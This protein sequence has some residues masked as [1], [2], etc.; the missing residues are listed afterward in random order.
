LRIND[1]RQRNRRRVEAEHHTAYR[2]SRT[3][4]QIHLSKARLL[5]HDDA[6]MNSLAKKIGVAIDWGNEGYGDGGVY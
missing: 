3:G 4:S 2:F 6:T 5:Y 1:A